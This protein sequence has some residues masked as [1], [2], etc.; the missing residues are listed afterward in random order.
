MVSFIGL[1]KNIYQNGKYIYIYH[2]G[3]F[4]IIHRYLSIL[5]GTKIFC[6][7]TNRNG[8]QNGIHN[9]DYNTYEN[10]NSVL[11]RI[12]NTLYNCN[13]IINLIV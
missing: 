13:V 5:T 3:T 2:D 1:T 10:N 6:S 4:E 11:N 8:I 12:C 7:W 9:I